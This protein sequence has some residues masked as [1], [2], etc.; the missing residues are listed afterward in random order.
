MQT[1][2]GRERLERQRT[3]LRIL[4]GYLTRGY[5]NSSSRQTI[6]WLNNWLNMDRC[7]AFSYTPEEL[8]ASGG[9]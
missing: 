5:G 4:R 7:T 3:T 2:N 9:T 6:A 8:F 1:E